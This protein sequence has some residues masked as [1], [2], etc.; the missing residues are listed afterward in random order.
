MREIA[1]KLA[2]ARAAGAASPL[3]SRH[4][5]EAVSLLAEFAAAGAR[6]IAI[7]G[8]AA[9]GPVEAFG[10]DTVRPGA[11]T[12]KVPLIASILA[13]ALDLGETVRAGDLK[14]SK[15]PSVLDALPADSALRL[16]D[17][18]AFAITT[19]DNA[20][21]DFLLRQIGTARVADWLK[22]I[23]CGEGTKLAVG[24]SDEAIERDGRQNTLTVS[25]SIRVLRAV[26]SDPI[27]EPLVSAMMNNVR[28]QRIPRFLDDDVW[29]AHKT[30]SLTGVV[31]DIG[32]VFAPQGAFILSVLCEGQPS[33]YGTEGEIAR[34]AEALVAL[35]SQ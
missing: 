27:Y 24:Y 34:L 31:N 32:I 18:C 17:L 33:P 19:S 9:E 6:S 11:S 15:W 8:L 1:S 35:S 4:R 3:F 23:G 14:D 22:S 12:L 13:A 20:A 30:G 21:S 29:V 10:L 25:D 16:A 7:A 2:Q 26:A 28:N 5:G